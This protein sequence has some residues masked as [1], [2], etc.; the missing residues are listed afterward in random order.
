M[1]I[2]ES[3]ETSILVNNVDATTEE[4]RRNES[5]IDHE[6]EQIY[7]IAS[8]VSG[9]TDILFL[10]FA[11]L[12]FMLYSI[13][14]FL[15]GCIVVLSSL[16]PSSISELGL[17]L[18]NKNDPTLEARLLVICLIFSTGVKLCRDL[19]LF[20]EL[21]PYYRTFVRTFNNGQIPTNL[22]R[23]FVPKYMVYQPTWSDVKMY[24]AFDA[25]IGLCY[26]TQV[27]AVFFLSMDTS[28]GQQLSFS[29]IVMTIGVPLFYVEW[30]YRVYEL[31]YSRKPESWFKPVRVAPEECFVCTTSFT[32]A[33]QLPCEHYVHADCMKRWIEG[34][35]RNCPICRRLF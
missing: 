22:S 30:N 9:L 29:V 15:I 31:V 11:V 34:G 23:I 25:I 2:N 32:V 26:L 33:I 24:K 27:V 35:H 3:R 16:I 19:F 21:W 1:S 5:Q 20:V 14:F 12:T 13:L 4:Q 28:R 7:P 10:L 6:G 17:W 18:I 8:L